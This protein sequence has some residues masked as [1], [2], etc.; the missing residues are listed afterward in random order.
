MENEFFNSLRSKSEH[1]KV[2]RWK[3][4]KGKYQRPKQYFTKKF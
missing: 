3:K 1:F 2:Y 4:K